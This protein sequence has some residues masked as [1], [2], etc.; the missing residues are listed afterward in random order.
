MS[1]PIY[2]VIISR[3]AANQKSLAALIDPDEYDDQG[4][5]IKMVEYANEAGVDL[6]LV[7]GS[8]VAYPDI[9]RT[10]QLIKSN[11]HIP[12]LLFPGNS[13]QVCEQVDAILFLTLIS[14]RNPEYLIGQHVPVAVSLKKSGIEVI[15]TGYILIDGGTNTSAAYMSATSPIPANKPEIVNAT[16]LAGE[17]L[18]LKLIYL[19]AGSGAKY[20]VR[21]EI[22]AKV[23]KNISIPLVVGGGINSIDRI[24]RTLEAGADVIVIG[25]H[26]E[27]QPDFILEAA[28]IIREYNRKLDIH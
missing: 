4:K 20:P 15:P 12:V 21:Q 27:S 13:L 18:G 23:R 3:S 8:F 26:L 24:L 2:D 25:N 10:V 6:I 11:T 16:A 17:L 7:G 28:G 19:E 9:T 14:G 5:I 1:D 22:I